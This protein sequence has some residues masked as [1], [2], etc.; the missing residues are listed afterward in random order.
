MVG[1]GFIGFDELRERFDNAASCVASC[2]NYKNRGCHD[3]VRLKG[4]D[5]MC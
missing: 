5:M 2:A 3:R 1:E 4:L